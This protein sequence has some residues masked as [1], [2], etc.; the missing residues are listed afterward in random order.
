MGNRR[1]VVGENTGDQDDVGRERRRMN[2]WDLEQ[3]LGRHAFDKRVEQ[4]MLGTWGRGRDFGV[5]QAQLEDV[6]GDGTYFSDPH[7]GWEEDVQE[8]KHGGG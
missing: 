5:S 3:E 1:G 7:C 6:V 8:T 4:T 2:V